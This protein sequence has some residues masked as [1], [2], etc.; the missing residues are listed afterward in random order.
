MRDAVAVDKTP[1]DFE[2]EAR[3]VGDDQMTVA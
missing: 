1:I 2:A 3:L